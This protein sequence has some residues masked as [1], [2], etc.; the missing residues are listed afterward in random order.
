MNVRR[1]RRDGQFRQRIHDFPDVG[2]AQPGVDEDRS[3]PP[4]QQIAVSFFP[5]FVFADRKRLRIDFFNRKP[6]AHIPVPHGSPRKSRTAS[7]VRR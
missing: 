2:D 3:F 6:I 5:M 7:V 4:A 1:D